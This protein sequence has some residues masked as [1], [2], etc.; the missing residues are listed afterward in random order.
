MKKDILLISSTHGNEKIGLE[1]I[2]KLKKEKLDKY[3]DY[4]IA[5]PKANK[6]DKRFL[7]KDLN[8]S[9]PGKKESK[10][11]EEKVAYKNFQ[12]AKKYKYVID[13]HE[14]EKGINDFVIVA[15]DSLNDKFPYKKINLKNILLWSDPKGSLCGEIDNAIELEFG[16]K[17]RN[18]V[19]V[20]N[21]AYNILEMFLLNKIIRYSKSKKIYKVYGFLND[22]KFVSRKVFK[23]FKKVNFKNESFYPLLVDQ[24]L[25]LGIK[26]YKMNKIK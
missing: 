13:I 3:F 16:M 7:D 11:Y 9:Y 4:I 10:F 15:R 17:G 25:D 12:I 21:K 22:N 19:D 5:N 6:Q 8:R 20:I 1:V 24:Y 23:D 18:R 2:E 26:C 14:A